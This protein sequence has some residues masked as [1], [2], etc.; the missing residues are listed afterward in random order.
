[1]AREMHVERAKRFFMSRINSAVFPMQAKKRETVDWSN[2][3]RGSPMVMELAI[4]IQ[5][6]RSDCDE[7]AGYLR[8]WQPMP[9]TRQ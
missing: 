2:K 8:K 6:F 4:S 5:P 3:L 7:S 1:M 9:L